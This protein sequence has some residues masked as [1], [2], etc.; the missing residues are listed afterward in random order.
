MLTLPAFRKMLKQIEI[1]LVK[2]RFQ[3]TLINGIVSSWIV[4]SIISGI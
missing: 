3:A 4:L 2:I 1:L